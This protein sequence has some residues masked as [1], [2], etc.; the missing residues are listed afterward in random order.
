MAKG[1]NAPN[2]RPTSAKKGASKKAPQGRN[3]GNRRSSQGNGSSSNDSGLVGIALIAIGVLLILGVWFSLAGPAG[4]GA[5]T[6][7]GWFLGIGRHLLPLVLIG[8]G[9]AVLRDHEAQAPI[10]VGIGWTLAVLS[11]LG[12]IHV[13]RT[14]ESLSDLEALGSSGGLIGIAGGEVLQRLVAPAGAVVVLIAVFIGSL[15]LITGASLR[16]MAAMTGTGIASGARPVAQLLKRSMSNLAT[17]Q[18]ERAEERRREREEHESSF[19]EPAAALDPLAVPP[20]L[21]DGADDE[22]FVEPKPKPSRKKRTAQPTSVQPEPTPVPAAPVR[23]G[24][25]RLPSMTVLE[26]TGEQSVDMKSVE[27]RGAT[28]QES[29]AQHGV[30]TQL[31]G[32]TVG[33]TVTRY[34]LELGAGVKVAKVTSLQ[35]DIAYAM[36][37]T[38][39]RILAPIPGRSAIGVEVPNARRQLVA[40]GDLL[41]SNE[42]KKATHPLEVAIG[43]DIAG[44]AVF[45]NLATTPHMLIAGAT[46]AG[47]S[48]GIN[49]IITSL[50]MRTTPDQVRLI[51]IDPKQVEMGQYQRLPHLL[52]QP[53]TNPKKAANALGWAVKEMERRYDALSECGYRDITGYNTA[54]IKGSLQVPPG[55]DAAEYEHM[56]Y[57]VIV[58]DELND[59]MMVA[60]RDVEESITRI[61]Q[62]ARAVGI[63]LIVATQRPSVN[64][65]TGV[66]KANVPARMAFAVSSLTDSRVILDQPGAEK[67]VGQGDML[68]LPGNSSVANRIQGSW[69]GEEEVRQVVEHWRAQ[70]PEPIYSS[71][72]EGDESSSA[73]AGIGGMSDFND[74]TSD[75]HAFSAGDDDEDAVIMRQAIELVVRSQLGSTSMLQRKLKVGFARA[76]RIMDLLEQR[77]V[78]GPSEGSKARSVLM[79]VEEFE[80][81]RQNGQI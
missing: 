27:A 52:T 37:A 74:V 57:I 6:F 9:V 4:D 41:V 81:L 68:L 22:E 47:K 70:A 11:S 73:S 38:D 18:S 79:T 31:A 46:G 20:T 66:I 3:A 72:V 77:G 34:E 40:L 58:V 26:K 13:I 54:V 50:L 64:V 2:S 30:D 32:F 55:R 7:L 76:G 14:P 51:L 53:V 21:Y 63:H 19:D 45:L 44:K 1:G 60:A 67:L 62:K 80:L 71:E 10:R 69:V 24:E 33:P 65:I 39:V 16:N 5:G 29:L 56:P 15:A 59:L 36:A 12:F 28:L 17:L 75:A 25:W 42:A 8:S 49:C 23:P 78:V 48:S 35:K 61:A 43:K